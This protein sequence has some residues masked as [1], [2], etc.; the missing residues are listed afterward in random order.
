MFLHHVACQLSVHGAF[1]LTW[2]GN[3]QDTAMSYYDMHNMHRVL[4]NVC[5]L[6]DASAIY[7]YAY[8]YYV[9]ERSTRNNRRQWRYVR[10]LISLEVPT[11][12][13]NYCCLNSRLALASN[14]ELSLLLRW[15]MLITKLP[16]WETVTST[17]G[18]RNTMETL[19]TATRNTVKRVLLAERLS[20]D[21]Y[22]KMG[23]CSSWMVWNQ[24]RGGRL[25]WCE[26]EIL[27]T[28]AY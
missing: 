9:V 5:A 28:T 21:D 6:R 7:A 2:C 25:A 27:G 18:R 8:A 1:P 19:P 17:L 24:C 14:R 23:N 10:F 22:Q 3:I 15:H 20:K 16:D 4:Y 13:P 11:C 26:Q 12:C